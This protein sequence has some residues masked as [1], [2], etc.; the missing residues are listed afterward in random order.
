[1]YFSFSFL[2]F[3]SLLKY[4]WFTILYYFQLYS[5][6]ICIF[7]Y[8]IPYKFI[9][10]LLIMFPVL[11]ITFLWLIYFTTGSLYLLIL[12]TYF[13]LSPYPSLS[14]LCSGN[15]SLF[16]VSVKLFLFFGSFALFF[17]SHISKNREFSFCFWFIY[18]NTL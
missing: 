14:L 16:S 1:M 12:F 15:T 8:N 10:I 18:H 4:S 6:V 13:F 7:I 3:F 11:Y 5:I 2:V 17:T 9:I